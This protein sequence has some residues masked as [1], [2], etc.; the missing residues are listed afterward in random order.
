M[1]INILT[2][3]ADPPGSGDY[4]RDQ[5][6][7]HSNEVPMLSILSDW[8]STV[9]APLAKQGA[10]IRHAGNTFQVQ[11]SDE[12]ISGAPAAGINYIIATEAAGVI[13]LA[14]AVVTT[15]YTYNP[16]YGGIYNVGGDQVLKD[17]C[18]LDGTDYLR[19]V[20]P[21]EGFTLIR[22][23]GGKIVG[24]ISGAGTI[25]GKYQAGGEISYP[26]FDNTDA[27]DLYTLLRAR[28][29]SLYPGLESSNPATTFK[30]IKF[31]G[32][33]IFGR[34]ASP[35]YVYATIDYVTISNDNAIYIYYHAPVIDGENKTAAG[36]I[37]INAGGLSSTV[38]PPGYTS[39]FSL[40]G[41]YF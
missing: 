28:Y 22:F 17:V 40:T 31:S 15:G 29:D 20:S 16:A 13:T 26:G 8:E 3:P 27:T 23:H 24:D 37:V 35:K 14:W 4:T 1:A 33:V 21:G 12:A 34:F 19:G 7:Q 9:A 11:T 10:F 32:A 36:F 39:I 38:Y 5:A 30:G 25:A 18:F 6:I 2:E 41:T